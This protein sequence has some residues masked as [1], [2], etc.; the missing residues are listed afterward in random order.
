MSRRDFQC[1]STCGWI[2]SSAPKNREIIRIGALTVQG[3]WWRHTRAR[4]TV[5]AGFDDFA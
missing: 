3:R 4:V 1:C 2:P 5:V